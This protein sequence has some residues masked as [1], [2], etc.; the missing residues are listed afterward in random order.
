MRQ[1][2]RSARLLGMSLTPQFALAAMLTTAVGV[3]MSRLGV[4]L[5][6]LRARHG[7]RRCA[8]CGRRLERRECRH[9]RT[10]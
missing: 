3:T 9:C 6:M 7:P 4:G 8:A 10:D 5:G 1:R 2:P